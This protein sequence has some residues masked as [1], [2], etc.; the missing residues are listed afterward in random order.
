MA[1]TK[2]ERYERVKREQNPWDELPRLLA[3]L[4]A[5]YGALAPDDVNTRL[6]WWGIYTQGDGSGALGGAAPYFMLRIR[7]PNGLLTAAQAAVIARLARRYG[8]GLVDVTVRQNIQ[9]HWLEAET[10]PDL[11]CALRQAGLTSQAACGDDPRNLT[12]CPLAGFDAEAYADAS[13][14][15]LAANQALLANGDYYNLP[16]KFKVSISG[17]AHWCSNPEINDAAFTALPPPAD[18]AAASGARGGARGASEHGPG[19]TPGEVRFGLWVGGGLAT[20]PRLATPL[21]VSVGWDEVVPVA[22]AIA[23]LFRDCAELR[24][25]RHQARL[26]YLFLRHHWTLARFRAE[27]EQRLGFRLR[28]AAPAPP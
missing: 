5:G 1:E 11:L 15:T 3:D 17:C 10:L 20:A 14:L 25:N 4:R 7:I 16:R 9:L 13:P 27:L 19:P 8:R 12:G 6:R 23:A 24:Q 2:I 18:G 22:C 28:D 26:K 21:A